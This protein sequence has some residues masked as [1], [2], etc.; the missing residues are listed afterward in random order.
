[1][2]E[3][4]FDK[5]S[6]DDKTRIFAGESKFTIDEMEKEIKSNTEFGKKLRSIE[7]KLDV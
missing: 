2:T 1:M 4:K 5:L 3:H 6:R 7:K